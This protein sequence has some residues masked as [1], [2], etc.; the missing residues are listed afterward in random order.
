MAC[1]DGAFP[2]YDMQPAPFTPSPSWANPGFT[3]E[4]Y[5]A[6]QFDWRNPINMVGTQIPCKDGKSIFTSFDFDPSPWNHPIKTNTVVKLD[7]DSIW[8]MTV[9]PYGIEFVGSL[10]GFSTYSNQYGNSYREFGHRW[11]YSNGTFKFWTMDENNV[12]QPVDSLPDVIADKDCNFYL[13]FQCS[14]VGTYP[15]EATLALNFE[16][17]ILAN[18]DIGK[19]LCCATSGKC[20]SKAPVMC[21]VTNMTYGIGS[22]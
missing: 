5:C 14:S 13:Y 16:V 20:C 15:P 7:A 18:Y 8:D 9:N 12:Y 22:N 17:G 10:E 3:A 4:L 11:E 1:I 6:T 2:I 21:N 19:W